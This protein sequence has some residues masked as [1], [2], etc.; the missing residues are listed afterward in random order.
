MARINHEI[1]LMREPGSRN[2]NVTKMY[3]S[4][5]KVLGVKVGTGAT[6][7]TYHLDFSNMIEGYDYTFPVNGFLSGI[8]SG[9]ETDGHV[10]SNHRNVTRIGMK[11][12][13]GNAPRQIIL[14]D[15]G[16]Y[17]RFVY[18]AQ[19]QNRVADTPDETVIVVPAETA[20]EFAADAQPRLTHLAK[21]FS[22]D[23]SQAWGVLM[24]SKEDFHE[25]DATDTQQNEGNSR[26][27]NT[28]NYFRALIGY[29]WREAKKHRDAVTPVA[30]VDVQIRTLRGV[31]EE[32]EHHVIGTYIERLDG[33]S[34]LE[35]SYDYAETFFHKH[36]HTAWKN[37]VFNVR[38]IRLATSRYAPGEIVFDGD[39]ANS[40]PILDAEAAK[41]ELKTIITT[42]FTD[43]WRMDETA[44]V[45][46]A[47]Q[48]NITFP[49]L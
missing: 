9:F 31:L 25:L 48:L 28:A 43:V 29:I 14:P 13:Y 41:A 4:G 27:H 47:K 12:L 7:R 20:A 1:V 39:A 3:L 32:L 42:E 44:L 21:Q 19:G 22:R 36:D 49:T 26:L 18:A 35:K 38:K 17:P 2:A 46:Q 33:D 10:E 6:A 23:F 5:E 15:S 40:D 37:E 34:H 8:V 16:A 24:S 11:L 30:D 45:R